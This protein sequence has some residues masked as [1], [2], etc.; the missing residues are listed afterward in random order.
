MTQLY[1]YKTEAEQV[2]LLFKSSSFPITFHSSLTDSSQMNTDNLSLRLNTM[3]ERA[4]LIAQNFDL[5]MGSVTTLEYNQPA[6]ATLSQSDDMVF[7]LD[8]ALPKGEKGDGDF[9]PGDRVRIQNGVISVDNTPKAYNA[10]ENERQSLLIEEDRP[11]TELA[12]HL[13]LVRPMYTNGSLGITFATTGEG[14]NHRLY[15]YQQGKL[16]DL[17][18]AGCILEGR[19]MLIY[20]SYD[21]QPIYLNPYENVSYNMPVHYVSYNIGS[22]F[23]SLSFSFADYN[24]FAH[25]K[26]I[27]AMTQKEIPLDGTM[28]YG[29]M[30]SPVKVYDG[31]GWQ[32]T[33]TIT[34]KVIPKGYPLMFYMKYN[35]NS[36]SFSDVYMLNPPL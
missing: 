12:G 4:E 26:T 30:M 22:T 6:S 20:V 32:N 23:S 29:P 11:L 24:E 1:G 16:T 8:L 14:V 9:Y 7:K 13:L 15:Y 28:W 17:V 34:G 3:L 21:D 27:V 25:G 18:P 5:Q 19:L 35:P 36:Y 10:V 31:E 2:L 33:N